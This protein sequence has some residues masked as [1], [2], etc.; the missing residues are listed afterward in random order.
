MRSGFQPSIAQTA[1]ESAV[2]VEVAWK[3]RTYHLPIPIHTDQLSRTEVYCDIL[4][5]CLGRQLITERFVVLPTPRG[6][7]VLFGPPRL[8]CMLSGRFGVEFSNADEYIGLRTK[9]SK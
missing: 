9:K 1:G 7:H 2:N 8:F 4:N 6:T 3:D 5:H